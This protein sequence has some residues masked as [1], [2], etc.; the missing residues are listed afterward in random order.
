MKIEK[1]Y[2][3]RYTKKLKYKKIVEK[4][5]DCKF[6]RINS[7]KKDFDVYVEIGKMYNYNIRPSKKSLI[8]KISKDYQHYNLIQTI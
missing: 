5:L 7:D 4:D 2:K 1:R 8:D 6:I 3:D